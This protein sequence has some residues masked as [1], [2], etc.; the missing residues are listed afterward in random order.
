[1]R[2]IIF[3]VLS[4]F[5]VLGGALAY[6]I[7]PGQITESSVEGAFLSIAVFI[8]FMLYAVGGS[9]LLKKLSVSKLLNENPSRL[10]STNTDTHK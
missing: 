7:E 10:F 5:I 8:S 9:A 6:A 2:E 3:R 4:C 1:M